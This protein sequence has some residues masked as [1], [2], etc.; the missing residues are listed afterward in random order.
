MS[1]FLTKTFEFT[2]N[3]CSMVNPSP[4]KMTLLQVRAWIMPGISM[5][6]WE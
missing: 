3:G 5:M 4:R 6:F 2:L 1:P